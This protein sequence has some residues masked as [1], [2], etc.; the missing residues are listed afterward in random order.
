MC[1]RSREGKEEG[2]GE[3]KRESSYRQLYISK[4]N[5]GFSRNESPKSVSIEHWKENQLFSDSFPP[6]G[7]FCFAFVFVLF[8]CFS[9]FFFLV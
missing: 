3:E 1:I 5:T 6:P 7:L 4:Q 9:D 8:C 2:R